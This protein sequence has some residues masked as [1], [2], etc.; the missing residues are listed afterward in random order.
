MRFRTVVLGV[1]VVLVPVLLFLA[2]RF[3][4]LPEVTFAQALRMAE[5]QP[6]EERALKV[7]I[8]GTVHALPQ[9]GR[10][11]PTFWLQDQ[12]GFVFAVE[13]TGGE[14]LPPL[15]IGER[16]VVLGHAHG[17]TSAYFHASEVRRE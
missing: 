16:V 17:G 14:A 8:R 6:G 3:A 1:F 5:E 9:P 12:E 15:R 10:V 13:Y 4:Q 11:S 7:M 2:Q